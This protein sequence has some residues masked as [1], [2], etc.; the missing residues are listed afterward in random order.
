MAKILVV[1][2]D[3]GLRV[4]TVTILKQAGHEV[5]FVASAEQVFQVY[6]DRL[7]IFDLVITDFNLPIMDGVSLLRRLR[8][9]YPTM[10][11]ILM[12]GNEPEAR[13][14]MQAFNLDV[15]ILAKPFELSELAKSVQTALVLE[16]VVRAF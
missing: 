10:P 14:K 6:K 15:P 3:Q 8:E 12:T 1:D 5:N 4:L 11:A 7:G 2:D 16:R 9:E 13:V